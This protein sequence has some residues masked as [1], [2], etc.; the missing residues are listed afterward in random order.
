MLKLTDR[1]PSLSTDAGTVYVVLL[2]ST[3]SLTL[4]EQSERQMAHETSTPEGGLVSR[5]V[6]YLFLT[7]HL[8][9]YRKINQMPTTQSKLHLV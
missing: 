3:Q 8:P 6:R 1:A 4:C 9:D 7:T 5:T 2:V